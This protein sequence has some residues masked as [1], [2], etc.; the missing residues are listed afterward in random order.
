MASAPRQGRKGGKISSSPALAPKEPT[1]A[2]LSPGTQLP[3]GAFPNDPENELNFD[4]EAL[5]QHKKANKPSP[6]TTVTPG[7]NVFKFDMDSVDQVALGTVIGGTKSVKA[8]SRKPEASADEVSKRFVPLAEAARPNGVAL[9]DVTVEESL[10]FKEEDVL[11]SRHPHILLKL[12]VALA[13]PSTKAKVMVVVPRYFEVTPMADTIRGMKDTE[14]GATREVGELKGQQFVGKESCQLWVVSAETALVYLHSQKSLAPF[15]HLIVPGASRMTPLLSYF[16]W[17]LRER[18]F[19]RSHNL[20]TTAPKLQVAICASAST[21]RNVLDFFADQSVKVLDHPSWDDNREM[22]SYDESTALAG[23]DVLEVAVDK[24]G[25]FPGPHR[26]LVEHTIKIAC[27][28]VSKMTE[29]AKRPLVIYVFA[30]DVRDVVDGLRSANLKDTNVQAGRSAVGEPD[31]DSPTASSKGHTVFVVHQSSSSPLVDT[32]CNGVDFVLDMGTTRRFST[33]SRSESFIGTTTSEWASKADILE[34]KELLGEFQKGGYFALYP[35]AAEEVF[36]QKDLNQ[37]ILSEVEDALLQCLRAEMP[38]DVV[39]DPILPVTK[40]T[41]E[42]ATADL[43][44][45]CFVADPTGRN[46]TFMGEMG[47]RLPLGIDLSYYVISGCTVGLGAAAACIAA[48]CSIPCF[49]SPT[50]KALEARKTYAGELL[51][52]SDT[53]SDAVL[54]VHWMM[55]KAEGKSTTEFSKSVEANEV[56][57]EQVKVLLEYVFLQLSDY[58]FLEDVNLISTLTSIKDSIKANTTLLTCLKGASFA[59]GAIFV[60][61][62]GNLANKAR[63]GAFVF[64]RTSKK[65]LPNSNYNS[66]VPWE[67]NAA[68]VPIDIRNFP[69]LVVVSRVSLL[70]T[71]CLFTSLL[72]FSPQVEYS[73]PVDVSGKGKFVHFGVTNNHQMKRFTVSIE[74]AAS[75][76][77][78][79]QKWNQSLGYLAALRKMHRPISQRRFALELKAVDRLFHLE[80]F[81]AEVQR[82]L[83]N[84]ITELEVTEHQS[85]FA[86][87]TIHCFAP[88]AVLSEDKAPEPAMDVTVSKKFHDGDLWKAAASPA[89]VSPGT[90]T[91]SPQHLVPDPSGATLLRGRR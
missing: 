25:K 51:T 33:Q 75:I 47:C 11:V 58:L 17:G 89:S 21:K 84:L 56:K 26:K 6:G 1:P 32:E 50:E 2:A 72:L 78:F 91:A 35:V 7:D 77:D 41:L 28:I 10:T 70:S 36:P 59:R 52:Q 76:L 53:L 49:S 81:Q 12:A 3:G 90:Q 8:D 14:S 60:R 18:V 44:E 87:K 38:L 19:R 67:A 65:V 23:L 29:S 13:S 45:K 63:S 71:S 79:R 69:T 61:E 34:R 31:V 86:T 22:F 20:D 4:L 66:Q 83:L 27:N 30:A 68:L 85:S 16:L 39:E 57:L 42:L 88:I 80:D 37:C 15:T 62:S 64:V 24:S 54:F 82:D 9:C 5:I 48:V 46:I 74:D 40:E 73:E 43:C 55:L